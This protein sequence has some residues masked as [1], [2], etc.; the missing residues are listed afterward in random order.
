MCS[1]W[2]TGAP[3]SPGR[4]Q[5]RIMRIG[6]YCQYPFILWLLR[7]AKLN[8]QPN[9]NNGVNGKIYNAI[10][11]WYVENLA[12]DGTPFSGVKVDNAFNSV[13]SPGR[14]DHV[15]EKSNVG[16]FLASLLGSD[17]DCDDLNALFSPSC[18]G[19][20]LLQRIFDRP[21]TLKTYRLALLP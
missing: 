10:E 11:K 16:D 7:S 18:S 15:W 6:D 1:S 13:T 2:D 17:F 3:R 14:T 9:G 4:Q 8:N 12:D 19:T 21:W 20:N 5:D